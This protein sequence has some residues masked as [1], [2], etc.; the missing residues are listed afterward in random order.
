[1]AYIVHGEGMTSPR[2]VLVY[3]NLIEGKKMD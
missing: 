2:H 1:M 3:N